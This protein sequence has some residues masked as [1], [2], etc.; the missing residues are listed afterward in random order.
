MVLCDERSFG[1]KSDVKT[2]WT[3]SGSRKVLSACVWSCGRI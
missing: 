1:G 2:S 3:V